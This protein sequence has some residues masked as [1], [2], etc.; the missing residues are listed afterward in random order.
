[1]SIGLAIYGVDK[2]SSATAFELAKLFFKELNYPIT[3]AAYHKR[4]ALEDGEELGLV[5][6]KLDELDKKLM[7]GEATDFRVYCET[8]RSEPWFCS[9]GYTTEDFGN[10]FCI[11]ARSEES[12]E[13]SKDKFIS[14]INKTISDLKFKYAIIG[15]CRSL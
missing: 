10:F 6:V 9:F 11:D 15:G 13:D 14:F 8:E 7:S 2:A 5:E 12:F 1:M 3:G 4:I